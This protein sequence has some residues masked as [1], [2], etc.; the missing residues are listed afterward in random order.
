MAEAAQ[1]PTRTETD[2]MGEMQ[3]PADAYYGAS[4]AR[5]VLNFPISGFRLPRRLIRGL[6]LVKLAA[7]RVNVRLGLLD[8]RLGEAIAQAAQEVVDGKLDDHFPVDVYQTGSGTSSNM[9][10]NEV[11]AN[12][13][14]ELLGGARGS[15]LVHPNDHVN[16]GQSSNDVFPTAIHVAVLEALHH[17]LRPVLVRLGAELDARSREWWEILKI[18]RTHLMDATPI[19]LGQEFGGYASQVHHA[20]RRIERT[21]GSLAELAIGGTAVGTGINTHPEFARRACAELSDLTGSEFREADNHFE[22]QGARDALVETS[23]QLRTIAV[24][25]A[26]IA[27]DVRWLGSGPRCGLGELELPAVQ[28]GSSIMP[29]K[30]NPVV[31]ESLVQVCAQVIGHDAAIAQGGLGG[32]FELNAMMP[33]MAYNLLES[34]RLLCNAA[35]AFA[36]KCVAGLQ[37]DADRCRDLIEHSLAMCTSLAPHIGYDAAARLAKKAYATHRTIREIA[38]EE[39]GLPRE[40]VDRLLDPASMTAPDAGRVGSGGT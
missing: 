34:I 30:V 37:P 28:P 40:E 2:S 33:L 39:S 31:C 16:L 19:R 35:A 26:K 7:A 14:A 22:A 3:V 23:G 1:L 20:V 18:G 36:D 11:L 17:D 25:L 29:G 24:S 12:R 6:G 27:N 10:V 13:A 21:Y 38:Y 5:A 4:T 8:A 15:R 32:H 9:N